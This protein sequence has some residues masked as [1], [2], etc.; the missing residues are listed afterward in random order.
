[1][2]TVCASIRQCWNPIRHHLWRIGFQHCRIEAQTVLI[3]EK[4]AWDR[5]WSVFIHTH[6]LF[7]ADYLL[8]LIIAIVLSVIPRPYCSSATPARPDEQDHHR[9]YRGERALV[10]SIVGG[11]LVE[12]HCPPSRCR[13]PWQVF[14]VDQTGC[15][16]P[17]GHCEWWLRIGW[18][19]LGSY[20][21][22]DA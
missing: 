1:M 3:Y 11:S 10:L 22:Q 20:R 8:F 2:R 6:R 19:V 14:T 17:S 9:S 16:E 18:T 15:S 21:F 13:E 4:H 7:Y 12:H 5:D